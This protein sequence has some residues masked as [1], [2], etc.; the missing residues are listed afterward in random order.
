MSAKHTLITAKKTERRIM[1]PPGERVREVTEENMRLVR[2]W[3]RRERGTLV[4]VCRNGRKLDAVTPKSCSVRLDTAVWNQRDRE[5]CP[6]HAND[7][8]DRSPVSAA[9]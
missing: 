5:D 4:D 3:Q 2:L 6:I 9:S 7:R 1:E 8:Y